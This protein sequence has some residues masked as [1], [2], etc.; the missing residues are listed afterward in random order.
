MSLNQSNP[1]NN[2]R[3]R[4]KNCFGNGCKNFAT[5]HILLAVFHKK[6]WLCSTCKE[7]F[8]KNGLVEKA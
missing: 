5:H 6:A 8:E 7:D 4:Y 2:G 3:F 1:N